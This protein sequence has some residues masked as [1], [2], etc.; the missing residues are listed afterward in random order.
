MLARRLFLFVLIV[1]SSF[2]M[3]FFLGRFDKYPE[4]NA[5]AGYGM[6]A[7]DEFGYAFPEFDYSN[8]LL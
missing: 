3:I 2:L 6:P 8:P 7:I 5:T 4:D 1:L